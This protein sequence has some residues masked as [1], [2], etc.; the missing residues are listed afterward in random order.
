VDVTGPGNS[1][2]DRASSPRL[3]RFSGEASPQR[4]AYD[5]ALRLLEF[6]AR[7]TVELRREL[8]RRGSPADEVEAAL[9]KLRDQ[10]LVDD[11]DFARQFARARVLGTGA[12]RLRVLQ[13]LG[14]KGIARDVGERA[15]DE[16]RD[17]DGID[18]S[19]GIHRVARKKWLTMAKLDD[20]TRR[21]RVY[22]FLARRGFGPDEIRGALQRLDDD[23]EE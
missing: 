8:R 16:L 9:A 15:L 14:R 4:S 13:E 11:D 6:R 22:A 23:I 2:R 17:E 3:H 10:K 12:S 19:D 1:R 20:V 7:S 21:R 5:Q 18:P